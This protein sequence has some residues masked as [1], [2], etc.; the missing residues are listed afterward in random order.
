M[1]SL[2]ERLFADLGRA[3]PAPPLDIAGA[4]MALAHGMVLQRRPTTQGAADP[5]G[6]MIKLLLKGLIEMSPRK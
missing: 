4:L 3:P 6:A 5:S 1:G 2:V